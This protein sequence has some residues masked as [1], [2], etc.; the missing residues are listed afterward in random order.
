MEIKTI[1]LYDGYNITYANWHTLCQKTHPYLQSWNSKIKNM[2]PNVVIRGV[3][4][5]N[6]VFNVKSKSKLLIEY[7]GFLYF[8]ETINHLCG[9]KFTGRVTISDGRIGLYYG[10]KYIDYSKYNETRFYDNKFHLVC[11]RNHHFEFSMKRLNDSNGVCSECPVCKN[12]KFVQEYIEE[13]I[14]FSRNPELT[15]IRLQCTPDIS[16]S[17]KNTKLSLVCKN[18]HCWNTTSID[19]YI[20]K[21]YGCPT[22]SLLSTKSSPVKAIEI[23]LDSKNINYIQEYRFDNCIRKQRLPF[24]FYIKNM[25]LCI[26]YDGIQHFQTVKHWGGDEA[27][28]IRQENDAIKTKY[29]QDNGIK[30]IR[31]RYDENPIDILAQNGI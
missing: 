23:Y 16:K 21:N 1:D 19:N 29:C 10:K 18:N 17:G 24:D 6:G 7:E 2:N 3:I 20:N 14:Y 27:F 28:K 8:N 22:C 30:L 31:I 26:E 4:F 11:N 5:E 15:G 13:Q 12:V 9:R 25:N